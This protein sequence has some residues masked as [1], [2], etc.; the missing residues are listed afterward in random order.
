VTHPSVECDEDDRAA[1][2]M[3]VGEHFWLEHLVFADKCNFNRVSFHHDF[4]WAPIGKC[5]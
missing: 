3:L 4:A 2:K 1:Y 5:T